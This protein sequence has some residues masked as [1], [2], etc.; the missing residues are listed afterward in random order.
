MKK[1]IMRSTPNNYGTF[2]NL[3]LLGSELS[4]RN[5]KHYEVEINF[6]EDVVILYE[7]DEYFA[8]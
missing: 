7:K 3:M 1:E 6:E 5:N 4:K 2:N 8:L